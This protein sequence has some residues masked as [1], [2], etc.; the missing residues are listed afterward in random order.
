MGY[1]HAE[2]QV[3]EENLCV[4]NMGKETLSC[5]ELTLLSL[6]SRRAER[7]PHRYGF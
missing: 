2:A 6:K 1:G 7:H 3:R 5:G 4:T